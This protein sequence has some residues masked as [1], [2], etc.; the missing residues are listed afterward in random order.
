MTTFLRIVRLFA[1]A[2]WVGGIIFFVA[3]VAPVAFKVMPDAH[4][5]GVIVR[6]TLLALHHIGFIAGP[7]YF[8][9]TLALMAMH[10]D[11]HS[12]RA[13]E[14][15]VVLAMLSL[16]AYL[17]LSVLPRMETDRLTLG[18]DVATAPP[19]APQRVH[20]EHLHGLSVKLEGT[21]LLAGLVLLALAP[22]H[23]NRQLER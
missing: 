10:R 1:L 11:R 15:A 6:G 7:V 22:V 3:A 5:A 9:F 12:V 2:S 14:L 21:V 8:L 20:F 16:T 4:Q 17:Q 23:E 19:N 13:V 18:G